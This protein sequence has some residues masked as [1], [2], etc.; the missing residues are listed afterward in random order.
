MMLFALVKELAGP[1]ATL[2]APGWLYIS[3]RIVCIIECGQPALTVGRKLRGT[4]AKLKVPR[5]GE[6]KGTA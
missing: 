2:C 1:A 3:V 5:A 6:K 4:E